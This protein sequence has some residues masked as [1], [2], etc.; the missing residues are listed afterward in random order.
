MLQ[1][2]YKFNIKNF[3][4]HQKFISGGML[5]MNILNYIMVWVK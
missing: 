4:Q 1:L 5:L 3:E 2:F